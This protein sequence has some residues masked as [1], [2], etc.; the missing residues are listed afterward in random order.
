MTEKYKPSKTSKL[1]S[2]EY[3][4][5]TSKFVSKLTTR[6]K[7]KEKLKLLKVESVVIIIQK[8]SQK[9][10]KDG[11]KLKKKSKRLKKIFKS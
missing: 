3:K 11:D 1:N 2:I 5:N 7:E 9:L 10:I 6:L 4:Q 8:E